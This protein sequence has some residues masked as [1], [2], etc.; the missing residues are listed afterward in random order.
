MT[1]KLLLCLLS[2]VLIAGSIAPP[3]MAGVEGTTTISF[4]DEVGIGLLT[5]QFPPGILTAP[6]GLPNHGIFSGPGI[7]FLSDGVDPIDT[8]S[9]N[10]VSVT[11]RINPFADAGTLLCMF[12]A[13]RDFTG[14]AVVA[15]FSSA[16][17]TLV[18]LTPA[19]GFSINLDN[20]TFPNAP[21]DFTLTYNI[22]TE[23]ATL[24]S[25]TETPVIRDIALKGALNVVIGI[26]TESA[27]VVRKFIATGPDIP[28]FPPVGDPLDPANPWVDFS[29]SSSGT[30][31]QNSPFHTLAEALLAAD[32]AGATISIVP[33]MDSSETFTGGSTINQIVML[34]N[35]D[36]GIGS[37]SIGVSARRD[38][39]A[40][41]S[42]FVSRGG[43]SRK[44]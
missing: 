28:N 6:A 32:P 39:P 10:S 7:V 30:G 27:A 20:G 18:T 31:A 34:S 42:G 41:E 9:P 2:A 26:V 36:G 29:M 19:E 37:V 8:N 40:K 21:Q 17:P 33:G 15:C 35:S 4:N 23:R 16:L 43:S 25:A 22:A 1:T 24:F 12:I 44:R 3:A 38:L 5:E 13:D 11:I 14:D